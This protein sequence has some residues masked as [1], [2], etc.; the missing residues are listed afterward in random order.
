[1]S[2]EDLVKTLRERVQWVA[3]L[4]QEAGR[5]GIQVTLVAEPNYSNSAKQRLGLSRLK[6]LTAEAVRTSHL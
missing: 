2:D 3:E 4:A 1:M 6:T 5:R